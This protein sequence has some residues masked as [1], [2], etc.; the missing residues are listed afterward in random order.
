MTP[1]NPSPIRVRAATDA[2]SVGLIR[3]IEDIFHEYPGCIMDVENEEYKLKTPATSYD[4]F[5]VLDRDGEVVGCIAASFDQ[6]SGEFELQKLYIHAD[7]RCGGWGRRLVEV[8]EVE[9]RQLG[10]DEIELWTDTRFETAHRFYVGLGYRKTCRT[11]DLHDLS[12]TTE[13]QFIKS[14]TKPLTSVG[15]RNSC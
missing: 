1:A 3:L 6:A 10:F 11:R 12:K 13:Y 7:L 14:I 2:D 8:V 4:R 9:A 15:S 5:W